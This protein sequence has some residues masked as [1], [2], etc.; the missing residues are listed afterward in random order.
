MAALG[1]EN[2][3]VL[4]HGFFPS[5]NKPGFIRSIRNIRVQFPFNGTRIGRI[6][7]I[8]KMVLSA[9]LDTVSIF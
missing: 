3:F 2:N 9:K 4:G 8:G 1:G 6:E 5:E 7:R